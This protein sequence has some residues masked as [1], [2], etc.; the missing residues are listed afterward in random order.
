MFVIFP[1]AIE[2]IFTT[3]ALS[4]IKPIPSAFT[5]NAPKIDQRIIANIKNKIDANA[6]Q[7]TEFV[8]GIKVFN[9]SGERSL[10]KASRLK[11]F[12]ASDATGTVTPLLF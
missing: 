3:P 10:S 7:E 8:I 4:I 5:V 2:V 11:I 6:I 1:D 9:F 12:S